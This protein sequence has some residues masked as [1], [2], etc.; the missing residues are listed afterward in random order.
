MD[1]RRVEWWTAGREAV[2]RW[3]L[4]VALGPWRAGCVRRGA[5]RVRLSLEGQRK[6]QPSCAGSRMTIRRGARLG[7]TVHHEP[8]PGRA[9][10]GE[11]PAHGFTGQH[12]RGPW[13]RGGSRRRSPGATAP[14]GTV[15]LVFTDMQG[16]T[17]LWER[18]GAAMRAALEVH[19]RVLRALLARHAGY[20]VKTQGDSF[21]V[22]FPSRGGGGALV[23]GG[24]GGA[25]ARALAARSCW[26]SP[27]PP[28]SA[29][30]RGCCTGAC[31][32]AWACTWASP[33][34]AWTSARAGRTT[35]AAR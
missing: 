15:A 1:A 35:S 33:S 9:G 4:R 26:P 17:R 20:E 30:P 24:P 7:L 8:K 19:D 18:C 6:G 31:A 21:M 3:T 5:C 32:C 22:A 12:H 27:R 28:R 23:P 34:A 14:T 29:G 25:A 10:D 13:L 11:R 16:S 2:R